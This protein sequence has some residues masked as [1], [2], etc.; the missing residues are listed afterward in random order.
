MQRVWFY[1]VACY[2]GAGPFLGGLR[3]FGRGL[4]SWSKDP[5]E[6]IRVA[7]EQTARD[8]LEYENLG[9]SVLKNL[10]EQ[11]VVKAFPRAPPTEP[12]RGG[13]AD[14]VLAIKAWAESSYRGAGGSLKVAQEMMDFRMKR[15]AVQMVRQFAAELEANPGTLDEDFNRDSLLH[16][17]CAAIKHSGEVA[18]GLL[19]FLGRVV[20]G[21]IEL[22]LTISTYGSYLLVRPSCARR[23]TTTG[24][25]ARAG[26]E[27]Q[28]SP[29]TSGSRSRQSD[30]RSAG[31]AS[32]RAAAPG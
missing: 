4:R 10:H 11:D 6:K 5:W 24:A 9:R 27:Q 28:G 30:R 32:E 25:A 21:L 18:G 3:F 20:W 16:E 12:H 2:L 31:E 23:S 22:A 29:K 8:S 7:A 26:A 19:V 14:P 15:R 17:E 13:I 1:L